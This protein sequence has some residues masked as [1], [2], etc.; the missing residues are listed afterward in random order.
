MIRLIDS[1]D[2]AATLRGSYPHGQAAA[3]V[4]VW[5]DCVDAAALVFTLAD[6]TFDYGAFRA[7]ATPRSVWNGTAHVTED[8]R[9]FLHGD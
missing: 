5:E 7:E 2:L 3:A 4:A 6:P 9:V 8:G 1:S